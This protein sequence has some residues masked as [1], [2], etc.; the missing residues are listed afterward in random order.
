MNKPPETYLTVPHEELMEFVEIAARKAGLP[1]GKARLLSSMLTGND[2]RGNFSHGTQQIAS[3]TRLM[4]SGK[5]NK[6]PQTHI[7][8]ETPCSVTVDGDGGL[9]YFPAAQA[10]DL[11][12]EKAQKVG[13]AVTMSCNHGHFGAAGLYARMTLDHDLLSFVTSGHQLSLKPDHPF[14]DAAGGSPMAFSVPCGETAGFVLDF[15]TTHDLYFR[16]PHRDALTRLAPGIVLRSLGLGEICQAWGGLLS[17]LSIEPDKPT[18]EYPGANQGGLFLVFRIDL[19]R[20]PESF[21]KEMDGY[22]D[23]V[24]KLTPPPDFD[25]CYLPG[26]IEAE[27]EREWRK[28]GVPLGSDHRERLEKMAHDLDITVPWNIS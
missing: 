4:I 3:Y 25:R 13:M 26:G 23:R 18:W 9:G 24:G 10:M 14:Y 8:R 15:G 16:N 17:G 20:D 22:A 2:L 28:S 11:A 27:R 7:T 6:D 12:I 19:F 21:K 1:A 5:L